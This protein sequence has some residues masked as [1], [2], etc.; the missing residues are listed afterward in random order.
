MSNSTRAGAPRSSVHKKTIAAQDNAGHGDHWA[1]LGA[2]DDALRA[3][4]KT[5]LDNA[6]AVSGLS[7]CK[8]CDDHLLIAT[9]DT[10][11][12]K[13]IFALKDGKPCDLINLFP[14][15]NSPYG[16]AAHLEEAL[17]CDQSQ[18]A[19]LRLKTRDNAVVYAFDQLYAVNAHCYQADVEYYVHLSAWAYDIDK[20]RQDE[21][22]LIEDPK[23]IRYHRAFSDV[24]A[25][26][27]G[28]IPD[29]IEEQIRAWQGDADLAPVEINLGHSCIYLFGET[30]GQQDEA[31]CQGQVLGKSD[32]RFFDQDVVLFDTV[33]LREMHAKPMVVRIGALRNAKTQA[34]EV[35]DYIQA[36]VWLQAAIYDAYDRRNQ[37]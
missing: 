18:D 35:G 22:V 32:A 29:D 25:K 2:S 30:F 1:L 12:I 16:V 27:G 34:I 3:W 14:A 23:A 26:S 13:Q 31:W 36:N 8:T 19:I 9:N 37:D 4:L 6:V 28:Q 24:V 17:V 10:C 21:T 15:I 5:A 7:A 11:H 20:S 33:V